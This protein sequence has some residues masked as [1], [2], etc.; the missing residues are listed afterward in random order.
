MVLASWAVGLVIGAGR[1]GSRPVGF[2]A[3]LVA[4]AILGQR[5]RRRPGR[6]PG[7][8]GPPVAA[9]AGRRVLR[10]VRAGRQGLGQVIGQMLYGV[11]RSSSCSTRS[12][13]GVPGGGPEPA[14]PM[15]IGY[16]LIRPVPDHWAGGPTSVDDATR[17]ARAAGPGGRADRAALTARPGRRRAPAAG[18]RSSASVGVLAGSAGRIEPASAARPRPSR[19]SPRASAAR[20]AS[21]GPPPPG[22][23]RRRGSAG[24]RP[25]A[26]PRS[27]GSAARRPRPRR[28]SPRGR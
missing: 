25:G 23:G 3:F 21:R 10:A 15:L 11:D 4:G 13:R 8:H 12:A 19:S 7:L 2:A 14:G 22:R 20:P 5:P 24:R 16:R 6:G 9:R 1:S 17:A 26:G 27:R 28:R 18:T